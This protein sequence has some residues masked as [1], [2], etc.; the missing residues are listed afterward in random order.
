[1]FIQPLKIHQITSPVQT[2]DFSATVT[3]IC[4]CSGKKAQHM[5]PHGKC[6]PQKCQDMVVGWHL[7]TPSSV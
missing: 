1:M 5:D 2:K 6:P 3:I 7:L 4:H